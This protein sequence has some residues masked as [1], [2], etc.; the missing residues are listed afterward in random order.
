[1]VNILINLF[2]SLVFR[3]I[4]FR[5]KHNLLDG[6]KLYEIKVFA[7]NLNIKIWN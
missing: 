6:L 2:S 5:S 1:M 3:F 7:Y 4:R